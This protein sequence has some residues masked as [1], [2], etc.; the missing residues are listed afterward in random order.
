MP[1]ANDTR[2]AHEIAFGPFRLYP[3]QRRLLRGHKPLHPG[4][5]A[6]EILLV[7]ADRAG[8]VVRKRELMARVWPNVFVGAAN[9]TVHISALRRALRDGQDGNRFIIK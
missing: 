2:G 7:L 5:R 8:E 3:G 1:T 9:L 4:S 6:W